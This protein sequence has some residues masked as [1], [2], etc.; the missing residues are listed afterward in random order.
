MFHIIVH[1]PKFLYKLILFFRTQPEEDRKGSSSGSC[2][3]MYS[4]WIGCAKLLPK[5]PSLP[6]QSDTHKRNYL[7]TSLC[8]HLWYQW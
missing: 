7:E 6:V 5:S 3:R 8:G 4:G 1:L 2:N